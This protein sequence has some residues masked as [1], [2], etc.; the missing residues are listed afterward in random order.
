MPKAIVEA[1]IRFEQPLKTLLAKL[2]IE[3]RYETLTAIKSA[4]R[5][6]R[7]LTKYWCACGR[8]EYKCA[9]ELRDAPVTITIYDGKGIDGIP[10]IMLKCITAGHDDD[11]KSNASIALRI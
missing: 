11:V 3:E 9:M 8:S 7:P 1:D 6:Y 2:G 4:I 10:R 5:Q